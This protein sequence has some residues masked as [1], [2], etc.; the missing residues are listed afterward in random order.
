[1]GMTSIFSVLSDTSLLSV[2][3]DLFLDI[4]YLLPS[5]NSVPGFGFSAVGYLGKCSVD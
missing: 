5:M 1:M 3:A 4:T 2:G